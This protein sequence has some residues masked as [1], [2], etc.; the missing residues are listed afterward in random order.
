MNKIPKMQG[1][2]DQV[3]VTFIV[4]IIVQVKR[5]FTCWMFFG[6]LSMQDFACIFKGS[7]EV[8][9]SFANL[10]NTCHL[11]GREECTFDKNQQQHSISVGQK[12]INV[13]IKNKYVITY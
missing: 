10:Q 11:I 13:L 1:R 2:M 4:V 3:S 7:E 6:I 8:N 5:Q 9:L 12:N